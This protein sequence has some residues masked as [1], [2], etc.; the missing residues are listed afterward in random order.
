MCYE[1]YKLIPYHQ[2]QMLRALDFEF[3]RKEMISY[4]SNTC[5]ISLTLCATHPEMGPTQYQNKDWQWIRLTCLY[6]THVLGVVG[7]A[8]Q[9][10][11]QST[12]RVKQ[13][14]EK[15][16]RPILNPWAMPI[17]PLAFIGLKILIK[18]YQYIICHTDICQFEI[19][20]K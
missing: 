18:Y 10:V 17:R 3:A 16:P 1:V 7:W 15:K 14:K 6:L 4:V 19:Y 20:N 2:S 12:I 9:V 5:K 11:D 8:K 13:A